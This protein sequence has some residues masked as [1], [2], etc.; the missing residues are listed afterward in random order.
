AG[1]LEA[2]GPFGQMVPQFPT[3]YGYTAII[4]AF[5]GRLNPLGILFAALVLAL[6]YVGG[7]SA[8]TTI[9]L[10]AAAAGVFQAMMLFFL[11]ATDLLVRYR[12]VI[13]RKAG[14]TP[15]AAPVMASPSSETRRIQAEPTT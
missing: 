6:T 2:S 12:L 13:R 7:E 14:D 10:P 15:P 8:Q 4:V 1:I 9:G 5:L 3:G 11:L